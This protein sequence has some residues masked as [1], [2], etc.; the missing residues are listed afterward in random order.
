MRSVVMALILCGAPAL[1]QDAPAAWKTLTALAGT[2]EART[3]SGGTITITLELVAGDSTLVETY[4]TPSGKK[5]LTVFHADGKTLLATHYCAQGNQPRLALSPS[6]PGQRGLAFDFRDATNLASPQASH[7]HHLELEPQKDGTLRM[8][9]TY[10]ENGK[11]ETT[12]L[13][14]RR[15]GP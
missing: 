15:T 1:A 12:V 7:L 6:S 4:R 10:R 2:W 13:L 11:D 3:A 8:A 9:E 5:T 14:F